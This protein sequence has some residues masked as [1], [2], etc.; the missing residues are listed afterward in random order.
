MPR[1]SRSGSISTTAGAWNKT[2]ETG[3]FLC[4]TAT[5][6]VL[7]R[8]DELW[9][10]PMVTNRWLQD[11]MKIEVRN[12]PTRFG[13]VSYKITLFGR[14]RP[15]RRRNSTADARHAQAI[16]DPTAASRGQTHEG[17][18]VNGKPYQDFDAAKEIV[19]LAPTT[20]QVTLRVEY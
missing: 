7:D 6:F 12:A 9:L 2:H 10:A 8:D 3:W 4:Q 17:G 14:R 15:H 20:E 16:G 11:G 5:M 13:K 1:I 18:H 19:R